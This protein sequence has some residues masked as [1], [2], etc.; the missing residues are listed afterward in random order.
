MFKEDGRAYMIGESPTAGMSAQK[1]VIELPSRL[2]ALYVAVRSN[3]QR[4][5]GGAAS[6]ASV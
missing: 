6:R 2:F 5:N 3:K 1:E 4:F